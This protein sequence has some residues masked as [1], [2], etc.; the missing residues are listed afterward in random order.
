MK[1]ENLQAGMA[2]YSIKNLKPTPT[3]KCVSKSSRSADFEWINSFPKK[4]FK[5][6]EKSWSTSLW[7]LYSTVDF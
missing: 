7:E 5:L 1:F 3:I 2:F 6:D 4:P